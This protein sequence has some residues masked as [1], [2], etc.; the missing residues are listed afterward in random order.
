MTVLTETGI[1]GSQLMIEIAEFAF[2]L[3]LCLAEEFGAP[4]WLHHRYRGGNVSRHQPG[5]K[6]GPGSTQGR[7]SILGISNTAS[8]SE[9]QWL[10]SPIGSARVWA[11]SRY[12]PSMQRSE[13]WLPS[14][15]RAVNLDR[16]DRI[17]TS[18]VVRDHRIALDQ[19]R[20]S[21]AVGDL[22]L[23]LPRHLTAYR[24]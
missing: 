4:E 9:G 14:P 7:A 2:D 8:A 10:A 11:T 22:R 16:L 1:P 20:G 12:S 21:R 17:C 5:A 24:M 19:D 6:H 3:A 15:L 23:L 18:G 13:S